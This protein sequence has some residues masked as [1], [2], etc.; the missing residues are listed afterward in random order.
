MCDYI[1]TLFVEGEVVMGSA[2]RLRGKPN[3]Y[4]MQKYPFWQQK[5]IKAKQNNKEH[6]LKISRLSTIYLIKLLSLSTLKHN[7]NLQGISQ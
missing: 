5:S 1:N 7:L 3:S 2:W 4:T 6:M